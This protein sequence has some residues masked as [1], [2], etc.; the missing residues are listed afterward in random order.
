MATPEE[1]VLDLIDKAQTQQFARDINQLERLVD[2]GDRIVA[3]QAVLIGA[4]Q[5]A[6]SDPTEPDP[7]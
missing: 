7:Q 6:S 2:V 4:K 3:Q 5:E 1:E